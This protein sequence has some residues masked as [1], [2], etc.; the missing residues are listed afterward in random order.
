[1]AYRYSSFLDAEEAEV[2]QQLADHGAC[3]DSDCAHNLCGP[4]HPD[5][6]RVDDEDFTPYNVLQ[7]LP[8]GPLRLCAQR[9]NLFSFRAGF[10]AAGWDQHGL[11]NM[12]RV[13]QASHEGLA[14]GALD[15]AEGFIDGFIDECL[16]MAAPPALSLA[17]HEELNAALAAAV[18]L[19]RSLGNTGLTISALCANQYPPFVSP[20]RSCFPCRVRMFMHIVVIGARAV[21][22][23]LVGGERRGGTLST[24][25]T[26]SPSDLLICNRVC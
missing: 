7:H 20:V 14:S 4:F 17:R 19:A 13:F 10:P 23:E 21:G 22:A 25:S 9:L 24:L 8:E 6:P 12:S 2:T 3:H 26:P 1:M 5:D 15:V 11:I 18:H 16:E